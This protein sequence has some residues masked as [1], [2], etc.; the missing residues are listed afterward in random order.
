MKL[1]V[2]VCQLLGE[3]ADLILILCFVFLVLFEDDS[4]FFDLSIAFCV[5][6]VHGEESLIESFSQFVCFV[7]EGV[8]KCALLYQAF[9]GSLVFVPLDLNVLHC[10][11]ISNN[12]RQTYNLPATI[13]PCE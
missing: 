5:L 10:Y 6:G 2:F 11:I 7:I 1:R 9:N 3:L 8:V 13:L 12:Q 4:Q